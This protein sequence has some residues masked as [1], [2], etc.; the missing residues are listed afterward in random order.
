M[1]DT[2]IPE[3]PRFFWIGES[4]EI[5]AAVDIES[6]LEESCHEFEDDTPPTEQWGELPPTHKLSIIERDDE[7]L[8]LSN[9]PTTRTLAEWLDP[10]RGLPQLICTAYS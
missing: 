6:A 2:S 4:S 7:D 9:V 3:I 5:Y 8:P 10:R 1:S